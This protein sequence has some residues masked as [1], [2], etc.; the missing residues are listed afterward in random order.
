MSDD[1]TVTKTA[2]TAGETVKLGVSALIIL[3]LIIFA[4]SNS[5][6]VRVELLVADPEIRLIFVILGSA[7]AG[8]LIAA[9][10]RRRRS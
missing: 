2:R 8:A 9:L 5:G 4:V 1:S 6:K 3:V 10:L 7:V